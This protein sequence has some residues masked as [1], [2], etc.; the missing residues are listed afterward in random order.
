MLK[1]QAPPTVLSRSPFTR[2]IGRSNSIEVRTTWV[3]RFSNRI[4]IYHV[5]DYCLLFIAYSEKE[6]QIF[7]KILSLNLETLYR[8]FQ[9][10]FFL[11]KKRS[12]DEG[13]DNTG[14]ER[15]IANTTIK[16]VVK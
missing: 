13:A 10:S 2:T 11:E 3:Q 7:S 1:R 9:P 14:I 16:G 4:V 5:I 8:I 15:S 6:Y 12:F